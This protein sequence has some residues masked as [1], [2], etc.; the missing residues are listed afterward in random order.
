MNGFVITANPPA[1]TAE[2]VV[3]N[4]GWFPDMHPADVRKACRLDGTV[5]AD[6]LRPALIDAMLSINAELAEFKAE[7]QASWSY[8]SL[9][10]VPAPVADGQSIKLLHYYRAVHYCLMADVAE[11]YRNMSMLPAGTGKADHVLEALVI[12]LGEHRRKQRWAISDLLGRA[13][14][15]VDLL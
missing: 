9:A 11:A 13:R 14:C 12:E 1:T 5:T 7:Q 10:D 8:A 6:R 15:T 4:D 3:T 2:P